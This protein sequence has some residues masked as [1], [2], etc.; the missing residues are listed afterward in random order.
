VIPIPN[1]AI[2]LAGLALFVV[3][4]IVVAQSIAHLIGR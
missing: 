2:R 1:F 3:A 4:A